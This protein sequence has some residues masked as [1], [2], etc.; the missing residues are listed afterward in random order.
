[1]KFSLAADIMRSLGAKTIIAV[2]VGASDESDLTNYGDSLS[3]WWMLWKKWN[4][5]ASNVKV[6]DN[7]IL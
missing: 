5:F 6:S 4:P 3:G 2:D 7:D 1:M